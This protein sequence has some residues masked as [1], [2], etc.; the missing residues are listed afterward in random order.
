MPLRML[1]K[2][3]AGEKRKLQCQPHRMPK[4]P[5]SMHLGRKRLWRPRFRLSGRGRK[6]FVFSYAVPLLKRETDGRLQ[7]REERP[8]GSTFP[9]EPPILAG[10]KNKLYTLP[11]VKTEGQF[12]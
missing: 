1:R 9:T 5:L 8:P 12:S 11:Y 4:Q 3:E 2:L 10:F 7:V 6:P